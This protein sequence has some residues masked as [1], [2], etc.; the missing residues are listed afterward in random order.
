[1]LTTRIIRVNSGRVGGVSVVDL[2][3]HNWDGGHDGDVGVIWIARIA[4]K[5]VAGNGLCQAEGI[6]TMS[7]KICA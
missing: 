2:M 1:M 4:R 6:G 5:I 7:E 3:V